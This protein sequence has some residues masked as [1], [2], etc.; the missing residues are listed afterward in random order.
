MSSIRDFNG[1]RNQVKFNVLNITQD[2][3]QICFHVTPAPFIRRV[4]YSFRGGFYILTV[5]VLFCLLKWTPIIGFVISYLIGLVLV[6]VYALYFNKTLMYEI[7]LST[8]N[9]TIII[10]YLQFNNLK[11]VRIQMNKTAIVFRQDYS[12]R[13]ERWKLLVIR[14]GKIYFQQLD[15]MPWTKEDFEGIAAAYKKLISGDRS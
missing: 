11:S 12:F 6:F 3:N 8:Q 7:I 5:A 13:T 4:L 1:R 2:Q 9:N 14:E 15:N 10:N